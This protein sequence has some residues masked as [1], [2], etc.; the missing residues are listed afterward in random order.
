MRRPFKAECKVQAVLANP[1]V[2]LCASCHRKFLNVSTIALVITS[3]SCHAQGFDHCTKCQHDKHVKD[4]ELHLLVREC[5]S[6]S[7]IH[8]IIRSV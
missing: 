7:N 1:L 5:S 4:M 6:E 8:V 3:I 2:A